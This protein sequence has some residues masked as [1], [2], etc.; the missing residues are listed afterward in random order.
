MADPRSQWLVLLNMAES[1]Q[2]RHAL[3]MGEINAEIEALKGTLG[4]HGAGTKPLANMAV[5]MTAGAPGS[6]ATTDT[7]AILREV[8]TEQDKAVA[9]LEVA[10][11][12]V[13]A[14]YA[15]GLRAALR[16]KKAYDD[17]AGI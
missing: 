7:L 15:H 10:R 6:R 16:V 17:V 3:M 2:A 12:H 9:A 14:A 1:E 11:K 5:K 13:A 8:R 4:V